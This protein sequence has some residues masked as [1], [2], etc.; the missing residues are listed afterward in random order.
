MLETAKILRFPPNLRSAER[1]AAEVASAAEALLFMKIDDRIGADWQVLS[2]GDVAQSVLSSLKSASNSEPLRVCNESVAIYQRL[3]KHATRVGSFDEKDYFLGEFAL[4]AGQTFRI[5]GQFEQAERWLDLAEASFCHTLNSS[6]SIL[7][8]AHARLVVRYD[9]RRFPEVLSLLPSV[10]AGY[11]RLGMTEES[12]KAKFLE[13]ATLKETGDLEAAFDC[14]S[15]LLESLAPGRGILRSL[16]LTNMAEEYG[17]R[18]NHQLSLDAYQQALSS[19]DS[20]ESSLASAQLKSSIGSTFKI[21]GQ[22]RAAADCFRASISEFLNLGIAARAA[23]LRI[24]L[25][26]VL[27]ADGRDRE[28]E[29]EILAAL[30][31]IEAQGMVTEGFAAIGLLKESVGRRRTDVGALRDLNSALQKF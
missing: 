15:E 14:F 11:Q 8:V 19:A 2:D 17:R 21:T 30:P 25:S 1:S 3:D 18:G 29:W 27:L 26:E 10:T 22:L 7:R 31:I 5:T 20:T 6:P 4:L 28:A 9:M 16:V 13:A 24:V 12:Q 23:S